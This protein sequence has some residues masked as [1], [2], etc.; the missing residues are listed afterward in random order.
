MLESWPGSD[1]VGTQVNIGEA[2][3]RLSEL[4]QRLEEGEEI[5]IARGNEPRYRVSLIEDE[6]VADRVAIADQ[7]LTLRKGSKRVSQDELRAWRDEGRE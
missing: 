3:N 7:L 5:V 4:L 1:P 6:E 2:R